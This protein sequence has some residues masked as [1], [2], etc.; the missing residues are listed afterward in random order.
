[1][2]GVYILDSDQT[3]IDSVKKLVPWR[4]NGFR[5]IGSNTDSGKAEQE[6]MALKPVLVIYEWQVGG[7]TLMKKLR[8][9]GAE[10]EFVVLT[11]NQSVSA[12][13]DFYTNGGLEY[14]L[15]PL[16]IKEAESVLSAI[17]QKRTVRAVQQPM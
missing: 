2:Y 1:M 3:V 6:I 5:F 7:A 10:C 9:A 14:L 8:A 11:D 16:D 15:K 13:R 17:R 12:L 4:E